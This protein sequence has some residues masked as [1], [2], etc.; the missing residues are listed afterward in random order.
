MSKRRPVT[1]SGMSIQFHVGTQ[2]LTLPYAVCDICAC[3]ILANQEEDRIKHEMFHEEIW[4]EI[5]KAAKSGAVRKKR[6][7]APAPQTLDPTYEKPIIISP[8]T[9]KKL[10][11]Y[12]QC[13]ECNQNLHR[14][15]AGKHRC[16]GLIGKSLCICQECGQTMDMLKQYQV[17]VPR[18]N[19][20]SGVWEGHKQCIAPEK[21]MPRCQFKL[22]ENKQC[23]RP[24]NHT[25][26]HRYGQRERPDRSSLR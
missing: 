22:G 10:D 6:G 9:H 14:V 13:P 21:K 18:G 4:Q 12:L 3:T 11:R 16:K 15:D 26:G 17:S 20:Q 2:K 5:D 7:T 1:F 25:G 19:I 24:M 8:A 23:I